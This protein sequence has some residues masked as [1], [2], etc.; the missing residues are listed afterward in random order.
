M[1]KYIKL[2]RIHHYIKNLFV[3]LPLFFGMQLLNVNLLVK[4]LFGFAAF[5]L[6][7]SCI[8]II[9]DIH[10]IESDKLHPKKK[11]R[12]LAS[13]EISV[14]NGITFAIVL[15]VFGGIFAVMASGVNIVGY[16]FLLVYFLLNLIY[17]FGGKNIPIFD[18]AVLASGFLIRLLYGAYITGIDISN[19]LYL[20]V[21]S[22]SFYLGLGKRRNELR[23]GTST[24][25]VL[26]FYTYEYL[27][28][29]MHMFM[30]VA[31]VFYSLWCMADTTVQRLSEDI[32][33]TVPVV[34]LIFMR[35]SL[36]VERDSF[37]DPVDV[38]IK[39]KILISLIL[40]YFVAMSVF[41]YFI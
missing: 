13:G 40:S 39:D 21:L 16:V 23:L 33:L 17:S 8:Y 3:F 27:D 4:C 38:I 29:M 35:Y 22:I 37:G 41:I 18:V 12:P 2:A 32:I 1:K 19:W 11:S 24:R 10:D 9:N 28:K 31:I 6:I 20:T 25:P 7:T 14:K 30:A 5:S 34:I 36:I 15:F 26:K